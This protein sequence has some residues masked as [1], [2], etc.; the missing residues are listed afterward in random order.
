MIARVHRALRILSTALITAGVVVLVDVGMTLAWKEP[1]SS[2]YSQ[3]KQSQ[4]RD[5]L[6]GL[7]SRFPAA[8]DLRRLRSIRG[9]PARISALADLFAKHHS[10]AGQAIGQIQIP[11]FSLD[12][13]MIEGTDTADLERGPGHYSDTPFPGQGGTVGIA[14]HRTTYLAPFR[15]I[16]S[17][18]AGDRI[19]I[20]MPYGHFE[21]TVQKHRV[22][23]PTQTGIIDSVGYERLV[24]TAC[25]PLYSAA[26]RYVVFAKLTHSSVRATG[27]NG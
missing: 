2:I 12:A 23:A 16:D 27:A 1:V 5:E 25:N 20:D 13:V 4:A 18:L 14:G 24:L 15:H 3:I 8:A 22:V 26:Q 9:D 11:R 19:L 10:E 21:Y 17:L 7:E 6:N